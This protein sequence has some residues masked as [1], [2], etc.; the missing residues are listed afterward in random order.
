MT[1][2]QVRNR[3]KDQVDQRHWQAL[4]ALQKALQEFTQLHLAIRRAEA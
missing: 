4:V 1:P 2:G 3:L